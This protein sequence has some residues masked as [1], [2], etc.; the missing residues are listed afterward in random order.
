MYSAT[1]LDTV[2]TTSKVITI[3][4][5]GNTISKTLVNGGNQAAGEEEEGGLL[6]FKVMLDLLKQSMYSIR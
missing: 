2:I 6:Y 5:E 1:I 3:F 4:F